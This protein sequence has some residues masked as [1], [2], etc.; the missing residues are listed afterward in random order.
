MDLY[1]WRATGSGTN[2]G[3]GGKADQMRSR[4]KAQ[5]VDD[6]RHSDAPNADKPAATR[7]QVIEALL[8]VI[9]DLESGKLEAGSWREQYVASAIG[10][11]AAG[12]YESAA[13]H[14]A[15]ARTSHAIHTPTVPAKKLRLG[16]DAVSKM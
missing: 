16:L 5:P 9:D 4:K 1:D 8:A 11:L 2:R 6:A 13:K 14:A 3:R 7:E 15:Q 12:C 10:L